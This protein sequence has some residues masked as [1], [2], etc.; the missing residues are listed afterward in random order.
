MAARNA[1]F[2]LDHTFDSSIPNDRV[3]ELVNGMR[4]P[5]WVNDA[6]VTSVLEHAAVTSV[7][8]EKSQAIL[9]TLT[10]IESPRGLNETTELVQVPATAK[11]F[12]LSQAAVHDAEV[13]K[14]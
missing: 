1:G 3:V 8:P 11:A 14:L 9:A 5:H 6:R 4:A 12:S 7:E 2:V 13:G 10:A